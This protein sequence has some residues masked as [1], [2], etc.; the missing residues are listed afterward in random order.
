LGRREGVI[1]GFHRLYAESCLIQIERNE[2][3][4]ILLVVDD[5]HEILGVRDR[6]RRE[7]GHIA[8]RVGVILL[9][10]RAW[11]TVRFWPRTAF[12]RCVMRIDATV[13]RIRQASG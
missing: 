13:H 1:S 6:S 4:N 11:A 9:P 3:P 5:E 7:F 8:H 10:S 2:L 12:S